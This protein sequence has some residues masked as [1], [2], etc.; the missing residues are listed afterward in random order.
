MNPTY[1]AAVGAF[2]ASV[3]ERLRRDGEHGTLA[4]HPVPLPDRQDGVPWA[5]LAPQLQ[6]QVAQRLHQLFRRGAAATD[7]SGARLDLVLVADVE[8]SGALLTPMADLLSTVLRREFAVMFPPDL[9]PEQRSVWLVVILASPALDASPSGRAALSAVAALER[10]HRSRPPSPILSRVYL[11]PGQSQVMP[12]WREDLERS[13]HLFISTLYTAGLRETDA[14]RARVEAPRRDDRL[15]GTFTVAASDVEVGAILQAFAWRTA[16]AGLSRLA[17]RCDAA[18]VP[19]AER[20]TPISSDRALALADEIDPVSFLRPLDALQVDVRSRGAATGGTEQILAEG[21]RAEAEALRAARASIQVLLDEHLPPGGGLAEFAVVKR[22]LI[23]AGERAAAAAGGP[24]AAPPSSAAQPALPPNL[25]VPSVDASWTGLLHRGLLL[26]ALVGGAAWVLATILLARTA[27][28]GAGGGATVKADPSLADTGWRWGLC[29]AAVVALVWTLVT[30]WLAR[31]S[32]VRLTTVDVTAGAGEE[33]QLKQMIKGNLVL[34][35]RRVMRAVVRLLADAAH[36]VDG[37]RAA[38][39]EA[40]SRSEAQLRSLGVRL[41]ADPSADDYS[42]LI[43]ADTPL[44][45]ALLP[46]DVLPRLWQRNR[47]IHDD[48][49]WAAELLRRAWP[50]GGL[51]EDLPF[52]PG[53]AWETAAGEQHR[54]LRERSVLSWPDIED[55]VAGQVAPFLRGAPRALAL[56]VQPVREDGTPEMLGCARELLIAVAPCGRALIARLLREYADAGG[57]QYTL[58]S[59][60]E[61]LSRVAVVR[62]ADDF[63]AAALDRA[64][65]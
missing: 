17:T 48:D 11:L 21:D 7:A 5:E 23:I 59:G 61:R 24:A 14:V 41:G 22:A 44:H 8:E 38:V 45:R 19:T 51:R 13:A 58:L 55:V 63:D 10:W 27:A 47:E 12:L 29:M 34:R 31:R 46:G 2:G 52:A 1:V 42:A 43:L 64:L 28:A 16:L 4:L 62:T 30:G 15:V 50:A 37:L 35:R 6:D 33:R 36:I 18:F 20:A 56:G 54:A 40:V 53:E 49:L 57:L 39:I 9:P 32:A 25:V 3:A 60:A 26:G 65:A